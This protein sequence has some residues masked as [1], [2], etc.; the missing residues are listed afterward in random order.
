M[1]NIMI[2]QEEKLE[3]NMWLWMKKMETTSQ[4]G[5]EDESNREGGW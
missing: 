3:I 1:L 2:K 5:R 4:L